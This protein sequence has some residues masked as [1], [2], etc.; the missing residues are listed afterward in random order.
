MEG[1]GT[2]KAVIRSRGNTAKKG[3]GGGGGGKVKVEYS[4]SI[5]TKRKIYVMDK[6]LRLKIEWQGGGG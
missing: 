5:K 4:I 1:G 3:G 2:R 6:F